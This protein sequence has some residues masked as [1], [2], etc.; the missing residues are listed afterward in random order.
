MLVDYLG[1]DS[2]AGG[3]MKQAGLGNWA[4]PNTGATNSSGFTAFGAGEHTSTGFDD[5][6][7]FAYFWS[8]TQDTVNTNYAW[9]RSPY[10]TGKD[11]YRGSG[12]KGNSFS[13]RC[14]KD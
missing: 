6:M 5:L 13:V 11:L 9:S 7:L 2:I 12:N 3:K 1:G 10:S 14:L 8:S 4:S